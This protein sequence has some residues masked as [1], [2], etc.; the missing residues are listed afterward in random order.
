MAAVISEADGVLVDPTCVNEVFV[1]RENSTFVVL[2]S[3]M[4]SESQAAWD[5]VLQPLQLWYTFNIFKG[6]FVTQWQG[7]RLVFVAAYSPLYRIAQAAVQPAQHLQSSIR[8]AA[9]PPVDVKA[10]NYVPH[11]AVNKAAATQTVF[12]QCAAAFSRAGLIPREDFAAA[13]TLGS[14]LA[15]RPVLALTGIALVACLYVRMG[16]TLGKDH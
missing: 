11:V 14:Q 1:L 13:L 4:T 9:S 12:G 15:R 16:N 5:Q 8:G 7:H 6:T 10:L 3:S 2:L